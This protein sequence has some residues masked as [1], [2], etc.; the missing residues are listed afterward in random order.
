VKRASE[1][2]SARES[3]L[4]DAEAAVQ[5]AIVGVDEG[6]HLDRVEY[7][8]ARDR[9]APDPGPKH[10]RQAEAELLDARQ[11]LEGEQ[12][13][14][15][16]AAAA[17]D[18]VLSEHIGSWAEKVAEHV[19]KLGAAAL[20]AVDA[21]ARVEDERSQARAAL[22]WA[23]RFSRGEQLPH[24]RIVASPETALRLHPNNPDKLRVVAA[25]ELIREA[26][27]QSTLT[28]LRQLAD[29]RARQEAEAEE[30]AA[31]VQRLRQEVVGR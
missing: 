12:L 5:S 13:R 14:L 9:T 31:E 15:A 23:E 30:R 17:L 2:L 20:K 22:L 11:R 1:V 4:A 8:A 10:E 29:E 18:E 3:D 6:R 7:A 26:I 25:I 24:K 27:E 28:A 19:G 16:N 21:L